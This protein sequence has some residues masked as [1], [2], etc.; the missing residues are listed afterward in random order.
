MQFRIR[1][2]FSIHLEK[3]N[4]TEQAGQR[5]RQPSITS[6]YAPAI[7]DLEKVDAEKHLHKLE[8]IDAEAKSLMAEK[9]ENNAIVANARA[10]SNPVGIPAELEDMVEKLVARRLAAHRAEDARDEARASRNVDT[11]PSGAGKPA[12]KEPAA[13][14]PAA[15]TSK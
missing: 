3:V 12:A 2:P 9:H 4:I 5:I 13:S 15:S 10:T 14:K 8:P 1:Q 11:A 6:F 7:V